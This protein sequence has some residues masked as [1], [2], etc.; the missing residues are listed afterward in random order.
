MAVCGEGGVGCGE[1]KWTL[2][3]TSG[4]NDQ[5]KKKA[6]GGGG[7]GMQYTTEKMLKTWPNCYQACELSE[8]GRMWQLEM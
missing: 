1:G 6:G 2:R 4:N 8:L 5:K 7:E 3:S